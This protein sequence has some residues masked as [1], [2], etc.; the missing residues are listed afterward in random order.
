M[1]PI[2]NEQVLQVVARDMLKAL[3]TIHAH[4]IIHCD[5]KPQNLLIFDKR[6]K[7]SNNFPDVGDIDN[8]ED[9]SHNLT[10]KLAD[11]G[12]SHIIPDNETKTYMLMKSGTFNY[13]AP[14]VNSVLF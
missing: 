6:N 4:N 9:E 8:E 14:E 1:E 10:A 13:F 12:I 7:S 3:V 2:Y 11:F 5:I